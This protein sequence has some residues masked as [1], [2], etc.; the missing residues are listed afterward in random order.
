M[1]REFE[2]NFE[3]L[4]LN[5]N[6]DIKVTILYD[7]NIGD[8]RINDLQV[9]DFDGENITKQLTAQTI[10]SFMNKAEELI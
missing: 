7:Y 1:T 10:E 3:G 2:S 5:S 4:E 8:K 6:E 9:F